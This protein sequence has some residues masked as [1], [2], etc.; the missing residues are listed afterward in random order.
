MTCN[1]RFVLFFYSFTDIEYRSS[2][3]FSLSS[4][5]NL[6]HIHVVRLYVCK[7]TDTSVGIIIIMHHKREANKRFFSVANEKKSSLKMSYL[8]IFDL[9]PFLDH[10]K[11]VNSYF[12]CFH[13]S[14]S[15][16]LIDFV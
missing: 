16:L 2:I 4:S 13:L 11:S 3:S 14:L 15:I 5:S 9:I 7:Q 1:F 12:W 6:T 8:V 10:F